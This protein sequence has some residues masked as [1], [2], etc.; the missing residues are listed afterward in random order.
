MVR[1]SFHRVVITGAASGIGRSFARTLAEQGC[2][3]GL[4]DIAAELL[5]AT[6]G[7]MGE[8]APTLHASSTK[9]ARPWTSRFPRWHESAVSICS[10][11]RGRVAPAVS[12]QSPA[13]FERA[14]AID[15]VGTTGAAGGGIARRHGLHCV[16]R[17]IHGW[18]ATASL[19]AGTA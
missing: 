18:L 16:D 3:L 17:A 10:P 4:I 7:E 15:L 9:S 12:D 19:A 5:R 6:A 13:D 1:R 14:I 8:T 11:P 2:A